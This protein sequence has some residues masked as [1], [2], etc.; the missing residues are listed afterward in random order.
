MRKQVTGPMTKTCTVVRKAAQHSAHA[1]LPAEDAARV[2]CCAQQLQ[3][4][5][6]LSDA[7]RVLACERV[8]HNDLQPRNE[9]ESG[10]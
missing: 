6:R 4:L 2:L 7:V 8:R 9:K 5:L 10:A 3:A 1:H